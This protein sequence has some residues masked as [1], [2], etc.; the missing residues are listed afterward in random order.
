MQQSYI[1][2]EVALCSDG[3]FGRALSSHSR[4]LDAVPCGAAGFYL[5]ARVCQ[6]TG[7]GDEAAAHYRRCLELDPTHWAA[8]EALCATGM[9]DARRICLACAVHV[10]FLSLDTS[11]L[12]SIQNL[13]SPLWLLSQHSK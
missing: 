10:T 5:L 7:R 3:S 4:A 6:A 1:D 8:F 2:A 9:R 12:D 13:I 11:A